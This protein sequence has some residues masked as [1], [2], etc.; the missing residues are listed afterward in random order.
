MDS[1]SLVARAK[2]N[3]YLHIVGQRPD[4]FHEV[5]MILQSLGLADRIH[6]RPQRDS[7]KIL[8]RCDH[9]QVPTD[10]TN[11]AYRAAELLQVS[12][13]IKRGIEIE[14]EKRIPVAAGLAGGSANAAAVLV[15]L[16]QLWDLGL[17]TGELA[18]L[19]SRLGS[20]VP[21]CIAGGT[22]LARG[23][24]EILEPLADQDGI[25]VILG[26]PRQF[27]VSTAWAYRAFHDFPAPNP[28]EQ[29]LPRLLQGLADRDPRQIAAHLSNDLQR[30]VVATHEL[31]KALIAGFE[32]MGSLGSM[33]SGSGP[34]VFGIW[35]DV[36]QAEVAC[37]RLRERFAEVE[38]W[39]TQM[40]PMGVTVE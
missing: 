21:F 2:V 28:Q 7:S 8:I 6:L 19:G 5:V 32:A 37:G 3:L 9:P 33:M 24:G 16:N 18:E 13:G 20:D 14:I 34:T 26:K 38:F 31:V 23:R 22:C 4:G 36:A 17:T 10:E 40:A 30:P 35:E 29:G 25:P 12:Y 1:C 27:G 39:L 11:L 15:G